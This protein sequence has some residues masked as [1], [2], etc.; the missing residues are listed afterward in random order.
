MTDNLRSY[1]IIRQGLEQLY[2]KRLEASQLRLLRSLALVIHGLIA[3][4][5]SQLPKLAAQAPSN[6]GGNLESRTKQLARLMANE[7]LT[8]Q[9]YWLPFAKPLLTALTTNSERELVLCLDG[10]VMGR[11]CVALVVSVVYAGRSLPVAW[12][13]VK[14]KK[15]HLAQTHHL[16]LVQQVYELVGQTVKVVVLGDGEFDGIG[17]LA[18]F[19]EYGWRY[20][21]R[22]ASNAVVYDGSLTL[23]FVGLGVSE[24]GIVSI[25]KAYFTKERYGPLLAVAV[26]EKGYK[27]PLYLVSNLSKPYQVA[28]YYKRR[29]RIETFFSDSK[30]RGFRLDKS[31]LSDPDRVGRLLRGAVLAY[32]WLTY[33]GVEGRERDWDKLVHRAS[34]TDLSFFQLGWRILSEFLRCNWAV[35]F[36]LGLSPTALF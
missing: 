36:G 32:W 11:R 15:G 5:H 22:T 14:G 10:S 4:A 27:H 30:T 19:E 8:T 31:H 23:H 13:V 24:S 18:R 2:P 28:A 26:W 9:T 7:H 12:L 3:S 1:H 34:R 35:P 16:E 6:W 29:F 17:L 25:P 20:V 21:S 33:L